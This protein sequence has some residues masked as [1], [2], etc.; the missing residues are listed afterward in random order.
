M[1]EVSWATLHGSYGVDG[2]G[3]GRGVEP[4]IEGRLKREWE[5]RKVENDV[6]KEGGRPERRPESRYGVK[7]SPTLPTIA[8]DEYGCRVPSAA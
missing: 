1:H 8:W 3:G 2:A 6:A 4:D 5:R 7:Y